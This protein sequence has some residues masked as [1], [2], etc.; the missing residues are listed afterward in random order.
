MA[1]EAAVFD[2]AAIQ[3]SD[4]VATDYLDKMDLLGKWMIV[5]RLICG[6]SLTED[7]PAINGLKGLVKARNALVHHKS[8]EWDK[9]GKA[10]RAMTDRWARF[11]KDQVPNAFKTLVLLSLEVDAVLESFLG[12]LPF[13]GKEIY[14]DSQR[15][16]RIEE[17]VQR[18]RN[19]HQK[20]W[21][22]T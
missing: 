20:N 19:I 18:C 12:A 9:A 15:H 16:P 1:L 14:A 5:P 7:G 17:V 11:E 21:E 3:L 4:K 22:K 8:K 2:L 6:R 13:Y 10:E